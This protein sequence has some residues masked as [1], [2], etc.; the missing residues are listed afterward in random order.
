MARIAV[1]ARD[2]LSTWAG[3]PSIHWK[4]TPLPKVTPR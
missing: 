4:K 1:Q 2:Q 3:G